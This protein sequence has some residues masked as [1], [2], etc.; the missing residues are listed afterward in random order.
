MDVARDA[1]VSVATVSRAMTQPALL[2]AETLQRVLGSA[3][4]LGYVAHGLARALASGRSFTVGAVVPTLDSAIFA[5]VLQAMQATL[6]REGYQLLVAAHEMNPSAELDAVRTLLGRGVDGLMLVGADRPAETRRMLAECNVPVVL[7]WCGDP[8]FT[9]VTVDNH[10]AGRLVAGH[11]LAFG[12]RRIG[13]ICG[14]LR[15]NDRQ[16]QRVEGIRDQLEAA[17]APLLPVLVSEQD[18][19]LAGGRAGCARL[20][21][22]DPPPTALIGGVDLLAIG[23]V[24]ELQARSISVPETMSVAGIDDLDM[25]AHLSPSLTTV[26][27]PTTRIGELAA[28]SV[29]ARNRDT[30]VP[31]VTDLPIQLVARRSTGQ[32]RSVPR[33]G[34][35]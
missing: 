28:Q 26:H 6:A 18:L 7:T 8:D 4:R 3:R 2:N 22:L 13:V 21:E 14:H 15:F 24:Q 17:G 10:R 34:R 1:G 12:H 11:L 30:E 33:R 29:I 35:V 16:R 19:T 27:I 31:R 5:R 23:C 32:Q 20:L 25:S 9:S